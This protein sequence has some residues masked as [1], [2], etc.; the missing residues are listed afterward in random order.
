MVE[1]G[2]PPPRW[3]G[4]AHWEYDFRDPARDEAET[5]LG[6]TLHQCSLNVI[7]DERYKY[8]HFTALPP[9]FFDLQ[10]DPEERVN[11]AEDPAYLSRVLEYAQRMLSWRMNHDEQTLTHMTL[12]EN[13]VVERRAPRLQ[14]HR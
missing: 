13:G 7:R 10:E 14:E 8:V 3:R 11:R 12:T 5:A 9:L 6:L 2:K 1:S 4:E